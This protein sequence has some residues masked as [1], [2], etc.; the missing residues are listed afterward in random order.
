[1]SKR[2][3]GLRWSLVFWRG[4]LAKL[5]GPQGTRLFLDPWE[6][7]SV[8]VRSPHLSM[9]HP[10]LVWCPE[11]PLGWSFPGTGQPGTSCLDPAWLPPA[12][13][14]LQLQGRESPLNW[15]IWEWTGRATGMDYSQTCCFT[16]SRFP[17]ESAFPK[18]ARAKSYS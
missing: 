5:G 11:L 18:T 9:D 4:Q 16:S 12:P 6:E 17:G 13:S 3:H 15:A 10:D 2:C 7:S 1:M 14:S 8:M